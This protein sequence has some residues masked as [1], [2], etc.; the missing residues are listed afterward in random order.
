MESIAHFGTDLC[1]GRDIAQRLI[2]SM[3]ITEAFVKEISDK[4]SNF[5]LHLG[6]FVAGDEKLWGLWFILPETSTKL[7]NGKEY[8]MILQ[9]NCL[10]ITTILKKVLEKSTIIL[11]GS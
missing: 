7:V 2:S 3:L 5:V 11:V 1:I 4:F 6:Q 9:E 8:T 10:F